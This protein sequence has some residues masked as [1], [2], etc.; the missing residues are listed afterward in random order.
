M[1]FTNEYIN[2]MITTIFLNLNG[3]KSILSF[4]EYTK[5]LSFYLQYTEKN[6]KMFFRSFVR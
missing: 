3:F 1:F 5:W 2:N 4:L 6:V